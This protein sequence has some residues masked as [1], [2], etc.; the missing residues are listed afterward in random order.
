MS[1]IK[2]YN[3]L[4]NN[5]TVSKPNEENLK[6]CL[7]TCLDTCNELYESY[8]FEDEDWNSFFERILFDSDN[9]ELVSIAFELKPE[10]NLLFNW[11]TTDFGL[12]GDPSYNNHVTEFGN[13]IPWI[14]IENQ[15][16]LDFMCAYF[17][18][19]HQLTDE[20][21]V[22]QPFGQN[23]YHLFDHSGKYLNNRILE[24]LLQEVPGEYFDGLFINL[25]ENNEVLIETGG[26]DDNEDRRYYL[27]KMND[28]SFVYLSQ[29][30]ES[31][32]DNSKSISNAEELIK[33]FETEFNN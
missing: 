32:F 16:S 11:K 8:A 19:I 13:L 31:E 15:D 20:L 23:K 30:E 7:V 29:V 22:V 1:E 27:L 24:C 9:E 21:V 6:A 28:N 17:L 3:K 4:I 2:Q 5:L 14:Q 10:I 12:F 25:L 26:Y 33:Y 18:N